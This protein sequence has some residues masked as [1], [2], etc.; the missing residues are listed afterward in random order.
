MLIDPEDLTT[1]LERLEA[2]EKATLRLVTQALFDYRHIAKY[3]FEN[4]TDKEADIGEDITR[5]ALERMG[6]SKIDQRLFGKVDY[7]RAKYLFL[8]DFAIRQALFVD[9]KAEATSGAGVARL[10]IT[11][12]SMRV[13]QVRNGKDLDV[14][15]LLP[16]IVSLNEQSFLTTTVFVKYNYRKLQTNEKKLESITVAA[17]PNGLLQDRYNPTAKETI[18]LAGPDAPS[19]GEKFRTRLSFSKLEHRASWRVQR[20]SIANN[21][22]NWT[23]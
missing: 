9:S 19:L 16:K 4:E 7:K 3:I 10:Q 2:V 11:Q 1:D 15:G 21:I 23:D 12:L 6:V 14:P 20:I 13:R 17:L 18:F 5:E 8:P 22:F